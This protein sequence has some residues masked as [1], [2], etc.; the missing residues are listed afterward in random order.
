MPL[1]G[2][3]L[4][5]LAVLASGGAQAQQAAIETVTV[6]AQKRATPLK[7]APLSV[8]VLSS[9]D[10]SV[11]GIDNIEGV[12]ARLPTLDLQRSASATTTSL[13]IRRV[14]NLG[15]I[16]TFEPAVALFVD[17]AFRSRS[18]LGTSDLLDVQ[19]IE[20]LSGPQTTL[21]GKNA[22]AGVVAFYTRAPGEQ[23]DARAELTGGSIDVDGSPSLI[24]AKLALSGPLT[25]TLR[26][27]VATAYSR[28]G[29]TL[30]NAILSGP[31]F[32][33]D[34]R[35]TARGQ[36]AWSPDEQLDLRLI[37]GY[38]R[39]KD[40]Q[41]QPDVFLSPGS[42]SSQVAQ[43]LQQSEYARICGDNTAHNRRSCAIA[44][45]TVD[46][47]VLDLTLLGSY[48]FAN[49]WTLSSV[50]AWDRYEALRSDDDAAQLSAPVLFY[51]DSEE[52]A[53][54]QEE[55]RLSSSEGA[56]SW[57]AGVYFYRNDYER[58][59]NGERPMFGPAGDAAFHPIWSALLGGAP[60]ALPG[61]L[62][63]HDSHL[64]TR[65]LSVFGDIEWRLTEQ[66]SLTTGLR[67]QR[68][69][70]DAAINNSVT[71][72]GASLI[73]IAF[74]PAVTPGGEAINGALERKSE[75]V[76]WSLTPQ[77]RISDAVMSYLTIAR[78]AKS[79]GFNTGFGALPLSAR[80]FDDEHITHFELG[81]RAT[82]ERARF[83]SAAFFTQYDDY[84]N[85]AFVSA[86]FTVGNAERVDLRGVELEG[87]VLLGERLTV[88]FAL[89]VADLTYERNV[90]G[91]CYPGR[92]PDGAAP[93]SCD[94]SGEHP[95]NAP[96]WSTH[97]GARFEHETSWADLYLRLDWS[98]SDEYYTS[99]SADPRLVQRPFNDVALR[100]GA[101]FTDRYELVLWADN[102][103][104]EDVTYIDAVLNLFNDASYQSFMGPARQYGVTMRVRL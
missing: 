65:Y 19:R 96:V 92:T 55:L 69:E 93:G 14:G 74:T 52:G 76:A 1:R 75:D 18:L 86:Q 42:A 67:W 25:S 59:L 15:N 101:R 11:A 83:S 71:A 94:L 77:Y 34:D 60:F 29:D 104:D 47:D 78:S 44:A 73:S 24:K 62:G 21:Y 46:L 99:F 32:N 98:W 39:E 70:K 9:D 66:L 100:L 36:L 7:D 43:I 41:G 84:Q 30:S 17:G 82:F 79:G 3:K 4:F 68:E 13:R 72:P 16:P 31:S 45:H 35:F 80:E 6:W 103:L 51:R 10:L 63:L 64:D 85:A 87:A 61:Q 102:L 27:G 12:A 56:T 22:S 8:T 48:R 26:A 97:L 20:V 38:A 23:W 81:A 50:T 40:N 58:G 49:G 2:R 89:S 91:M 90:S 28:H 88:D 5:A 53:S 33:D 54:L 57:L 95:N 37:A